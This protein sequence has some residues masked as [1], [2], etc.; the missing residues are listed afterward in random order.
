MNLPLRVLIVGQ[1]PLARAGLASALSEQQ[2]CE[3]VGQLDLE[4]SASEALALFRPEVVVWDQGWA[5]PNGS[6]LAALLGYL[7]A[8]AVVLALATESQGALELWSSGVRAVLPRQASGASIAAA[9][10]ALA[11]GLAVTHPSFVDHLPWTSAAPDGLPTEE[12]TAR[13]LEVL[14]QLAEGLPNKAIARRLDISEH[15]VKFHVNAILR[16][17]QAHSRTEAVVQ[18]TRLGLILL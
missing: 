5:V 12:L 3:V 9:V 1:D 14:Q 13:E 6:D 2:G 11:Q 16:K 18:A 7:E 8:E 4:T 15:T 10:A 17:L